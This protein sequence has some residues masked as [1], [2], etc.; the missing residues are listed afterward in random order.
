MAKGG[1]V[2]DAAA[3]LSLQPLTSMAQAPEVERDTINFDED[4][5]IKLSDGRV[6]HIIEGTTSKQDMWVMTRLDR[7]GLEAIAQTYNTPEQLDTLA[8]KLVE[9]AYEKGLLYEVLAGIL[10]EENVKWSREHA[11]ENAEY[12]SNLTNPADK[13]AIQGPIASI[14]LLYFASGLASKLTSLKSSAES[15]GSEVSPGAPPISVLSE[16]QKQGSSSLSESSAPAGPPLYDSSN[17]GLKI[18]ETGTSS[19]GK[20]RRTTTTKRSSS[21]TGPSGSSA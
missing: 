12:F 18:S 11:L 5:R 6:F 14:L 17:E 2:A 4:T 15:E 1:A 13:A 20:S 10:V 21:S 8:V 3:P 9:E 19:R 16:I 7:A